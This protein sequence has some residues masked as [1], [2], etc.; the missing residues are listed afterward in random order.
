MKKIL[1]TLFAI[2]SSLASFANHSQ[3]QTSVL[4]GTYSE[5]H[6]IQSS[7]D[8]DMVKSAVD[9]YVASTPEVGFSSTLTSILIDDLQP[10]HDS[11]VAYL[12]LKF[13]NDDTNITLGIQLNKVHNENG[14]ISFYL[15]KDFLENGNDTVA[16]RKWTCT[17]PKDCS[18]C[19]P[20]RK[21]FLGLGGVYKCP[22]S[23]NEEKN[24]TYSSSGGSDF[25]WGGVLGI[26]TA[27]IG[28]IAANN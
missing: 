14:T 16:A 2:I 28:I 3:N 12:I 13:T 23:E 5:Q 17:A 7:V 15:D 25:P 19:I 11:S 24:C 10:S 27:L 20:K 21:G 9:E 6:G 8:L 22:C 18:G 4:I 1:L 26:V